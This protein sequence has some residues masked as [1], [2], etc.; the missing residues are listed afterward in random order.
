MIK[1]LSILMIIGALFVGV[2]ANEVETSLNV[3]FGH[4]NLQLVAVRTGLAPNASI[5]V[6]YG[7]VAFLV[8][9]Y[10]VIEGS[11]DKEEEIDYR[12]IYKIGNHAFAIGINDLGTIGDLDERAD[13]LAYNYQLSGGKLG[14]VYGK[15]N[16]KNEAGGFIFANGSIA[17]GL[18]L[19]ANAGREMSSF[20]EYQ[21]L[22]LTHKASV[23]G[24]FDIISNLSYQNDGT[25]DGWY[26]TVNLVYHLK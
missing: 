16:S 10:H 5:K 17:Q 20:K 25:N 18:I 2:N 24:G 11:L 9:G 26:A 14:I 13:V 12:L 8:G 6:N 19:G 3:G 22:Y 1:F 4:Q 23:G 7:D 21:T 15:L